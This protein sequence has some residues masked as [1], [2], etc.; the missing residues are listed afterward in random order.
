MLREKLNQ[1]LASRKPFA[2]DSLN[3]TGFFSALLVNIIHWLLLYFKLNLGGTNILL[4]YNVVYGPES[5]GPAVYAYNL[6]AV[7]LLVLVVNLFLASSFYKKE[8]LPA[9]FLGFAT[10]AIQLIFLAAG[11]VLIVINA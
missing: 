10:L 11:I 8:K 1:V 5:I 4:H 2:S 6:P 3:R 7:A 9:Y